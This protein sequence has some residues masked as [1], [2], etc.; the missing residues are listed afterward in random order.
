LEELEIS[1]GGATIL[2]GLRILAIASII[3]LDI[4]NP[5]LYR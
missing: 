3:L 1:D 5:S 2:L 4:A